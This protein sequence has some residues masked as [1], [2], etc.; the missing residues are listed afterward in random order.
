MLIFRA[1]ATCGRMRRIFLLETSLILFTEA[2][3][4][5]AVFFVV[6]VVVFIVVVV[7]VVVVVCVFFFAH[8]TLRCPHNLNAW[9]RLVLV[10]L[11]IEVK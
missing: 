1:W 4:T 6:V 9:N 11:A 5:L 7:V 10:Q 2:V 3:V 8:I